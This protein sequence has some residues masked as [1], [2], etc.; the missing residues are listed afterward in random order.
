[1]AVLFSLPTTVAAPPVAS[2]SPA[3]AEPQKVDYMNLHCPIPYEE[4]HREA[5]NAGGGRGLG[6]GADGGGCGVGGGI[7]SGAGSAGGF[8]AGGGLH[9]MYCHPKRRHKQVVLSILTPLR[10]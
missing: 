2:S 10:F 6:G 4:I 3:V 7:G 1:M 9:G 5:L 8:G